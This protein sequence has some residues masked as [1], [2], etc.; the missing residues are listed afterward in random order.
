MN[1]SP[2]SVRAKDHPVA[3]APDT[4]LARGGSHLTLAA[5]LLPSNLFLTY[6]PPNP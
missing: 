1:I 5:F 2:G 6:N 3:T 4:D